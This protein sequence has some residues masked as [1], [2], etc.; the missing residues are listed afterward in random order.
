LN[1]QTGS[2]HDDSNT[3]G[4]SR[5]A[6]SIMADEA[7]EIATPEVPA[8]PAAPP[9]TA[10]QKLAQTLAASTPETPPLAETVEPAKPTFVERLKAEFG[11]EGVDSDEQ[12]Q[13]R[14]L[15]AYKRDRDSL[16][17]AQQRA[18]EQARIAAALA[19]GRTA[20]PAVPQTAPANDHWWQ[21]P[22]I[23]EKMLDLY[24]TSTVDAATGREKVDWRP[25]TPPELIAQYNR[26]EA[27]IKEWT[28]NLVRR[29]HEVLPKIIAYE[30]RRIVQE[31]LSQ[32]Q[33]QQQ[34]VSFLDNFRN[35]NPWL[36]NIDPV[37]N[38]PAM[39]DGRFGLSPEGQKF[40][41]YLTEAEQLGIA[42]VQK[43]FAYANRLRAA[44][45]AS[46]K[47]LPNAADVNAQRK[48]ELLAA[49]AGGGIPD[50][51]GSVPT[52]ASQGRTQNQNLSAG[53]KLRLQMIRDGIAP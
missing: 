45:I 53:E 6:R 42:D 25:G 19:T 12:A 21:A 18:E 36:F 34:A 10:G 44:D 29:P 27:T 35:E 7:P 37:T 51:S 16:T 28:E 43:Q 3:R 13:E 24:Q 46:S 47:A 14:L 26:H 50:K 9:Q 40:Q 5:Q 52:P 30:A 32:S 31:E 15:E 48:R 17:A 38:K 20:E 2:P 23:D 22:A 39:A 8:T 4:F 49:G 11:F 41:S 1:G 33:Q